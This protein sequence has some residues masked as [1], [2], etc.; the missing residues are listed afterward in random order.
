MSWSPHLKNPGFKIMFFKIICINQLQDFVP[1]FALLVFQQ[2]KP[3]Q[4]R[5]K[6]LFLTYLP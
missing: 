4:Q 5:Q 6:L 3:I 1:N 2:Q